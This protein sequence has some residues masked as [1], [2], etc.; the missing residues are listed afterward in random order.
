MQKFVND[1]LDDVS[2]RARRALE[3]N[4]VAIFIYIDTFHINFFR[5]LWR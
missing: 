5:R 1:Y 4:W 2:E 3:E